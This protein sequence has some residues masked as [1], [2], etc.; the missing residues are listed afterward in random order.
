MHEFCFDL[1]VP[2][3]LKIYLYIV[4]TESAHDWAVPVQVDAMG[5]E[6]FFGHQLIGR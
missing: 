4:C 5:L 3:S 6:H 2:D 1:F